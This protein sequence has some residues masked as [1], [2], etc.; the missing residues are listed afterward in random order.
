[1]N[2]SNNPQRSLFDTKEHT[3]QKDTM[4]N[5]YNI[6]AHKKRELDALVDICIQKNESPTR[7]MIFPFAVNHL[8]E[9]FLHPLDRKGF[10]LSKEGEYDG[11]DQ[12]SAVG[13]IIDVLEWSDRYY[14]NFKFCKKL[15]DKHWEINEE[16][17]EEI[18]GLKTLLSNYEEYLFS[19]WF[20][21]SDFT[22]IENETK[23]WFKFNEY[24]S[25]KEGVVKNFYPDKLQYVISND[26][27]KEG[28]YLIDI[29]RVS[30]EQNLLETKDV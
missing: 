20:E 1:M 28:G 10:P 22:P 27:L 6:P 25:E 11:S 17:Y 15:E 5:P 4:T 7:E 16:L 3:I 21:K 13:D 23:V 29:G 24:S 12:E 8:Y 14:D 26:P 19:Q 9:Y 2:T 18:D 30:K